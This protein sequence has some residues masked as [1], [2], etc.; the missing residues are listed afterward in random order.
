MPSNWEIPDN[1]GRPFPYT[2]EQLDAIFAELAP[3]EARSEE[4]ARNARAAYST[5]TAECFVN[6]WVAAVGGEIVAAAP[7]Y[8][9]LQELLRQAGLLGT[10][11]IVRNFTGPERLTAARVLPLRA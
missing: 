7:T 6:H 10:P 8:V 9:E 4:F 11:D 3:I 5:E 1:P 2:P